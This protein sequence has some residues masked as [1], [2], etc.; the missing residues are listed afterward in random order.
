MVCNS[1]LLDS[2]VHMPSFYLSLYSI[3]TDVQILLHWLKTKEGGG[4]IWGY[5][6][7]YNP[8]KLKDI[9]R[10]WRELNRIYKSLKVRQLDISSTNIVLSYFNYYTKTSI[11]IQG[12]HIFKSLK[13]FSFP[14]NILYD[15]KNSTNILKW[16]R[17]STWNF[18]FFE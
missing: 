15:P 14:I 10:I 8:S 5:R 11:S 13:E 9:Y 16:K 12:V 18:H 1:M 3:H 6:I 2:T 17:A 4:S 7:H